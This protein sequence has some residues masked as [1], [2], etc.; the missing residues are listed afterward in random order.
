[1]DLKIFFTQK[2]KSTSSVNS[3]A[4]KSFTTVWMYDKS[5]S[6]LSVISLLNGLIQD[7]LK[8]VVHERS[9]RVDLSVP[10]MHTDQNDPELICLIMKYKIHF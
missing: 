3:F 7:H 2:L 10:L 4:L 6:E 5:L 1:M 9:G 8:I